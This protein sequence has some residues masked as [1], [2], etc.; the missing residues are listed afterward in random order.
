MKPN[1]LA[2]RLFVTAAAWVLVVLPIAGWIIFSRYRYEAMTA[3]DTRISFFL[4]VVIS[5]ADE[6]SENGPSPA[7]QLGR[8]AVRDHAFG[9]VLADQAARRQAGPTCCARVRLPAT[10]CRCPASTT[11]SPTSKEVRWANLIGP[12]GAARARRR[13]D[14]RVRRGQ[15]GAALLGRRRRQAERGRGQPRR[16]PHPAH[17]GPGARRRRPARRHAVPDPLRPVPALAGWSRAWPPSA[18]ARRPGSTA[19]CPPRSSRCSRSST[20]CSSPTRRSS[21]GRAPTSAI[22]RTR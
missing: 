20:R 15:G 4:T 9:L 6:H 19:T 8:G 5:D 21:S 11:S 12:G 22:S 16:L 10:L 14:L 3:F 18:R 17:S 2:F 1:S 7:Q 13:A